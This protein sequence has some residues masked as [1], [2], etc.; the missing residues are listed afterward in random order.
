MSAHNLGYD[1][2]AQDKTDQ[3]AVHRLGRDDNVL[4]AR[5]LILAD[6][7]RAADSFRRS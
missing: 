1:R 5:A 7:S 3:M 2:S 6:A 4:A